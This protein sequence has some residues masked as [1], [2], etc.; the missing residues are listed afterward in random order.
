M[1]SGSRCSGAG[2]LG[3]GQGWVGQ[4]STGKRDCGHPAGMSW[5]VALG[6][7]LW[8]GLQSLLRPQWPDSR[9]WGPSTAGDSVTPHQLEGA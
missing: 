8:Q 5:A 1:R 9:D 7:P 2:T 3:E 4:A 6:E